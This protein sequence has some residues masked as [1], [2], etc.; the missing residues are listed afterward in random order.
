M[1]AHEG[2]I[3]LCGQE[4]VVQIYRVGECIVIGYDFAFFGMVVKVNRV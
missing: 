3:G 1:D 2:V 4:S